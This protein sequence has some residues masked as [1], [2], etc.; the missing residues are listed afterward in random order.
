MDAPE[1]AGARLRVV[2]PLHE[3]ERPSPRQE[4]RVLIASGHSLLRAGYRAL[5]ESAEGI[6]IAAEAATVEEAVALAHWAEA[7]VV[8]LE[9][10]PAADA[11]E[12]IRAISDLPA[13][14]VIVLSG[15]EHADQAF[16]V[17]RAGASGFLLMD[18]D[19]AEL[20]GAVH[21]VAGGEAALSPSVTRQL[22][23][24]FAAQPDRSHAR[25]GLEE[26]TPREREVMA[27]AAR[28]LNNDE[29]GESLAVSQSTA[30]THL[31]R[32]MMKLRARNRAQLVAFAYESGLVASD[33][34][35]LGAV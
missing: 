1:P 2:P 14:N 9:M 25:D 28:G 7:D 5:L 29:I 15:S 20:V 23:S 26:L 8:L 4:V 10:G 27:L 31:N 21:A 6:S 34:S 17:L 24:R 11:I 19:P 22:I 16:A 33:R 12:S 3:F 35:E 13:A 18:C 32:A 30:K